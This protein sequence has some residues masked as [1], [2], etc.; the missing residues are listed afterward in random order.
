MGISLPEN[1]PPKT[2]HDHDHDISETLGKLSLNQNE[3]ADLLLESVEK[4]LAKISLVI[5]EEE[6][7]GEEKGDKEEEKEEE[8][9]GDKEEEEEEE[10]KKIS[11]D[12]VIEWKKQVNDDVK[13]DKKEIYDDVKNDK[14]KIVDVGLREEKTEVKEEE[15]DEVKEE[16]EK[17][18]EEEEEEEVK[19]LTVKKEDVYDNDDKEEEEKEEKKNK[20]KE[21]EED[22][23]MTHKI[24]KLSEKVNTDLVMDGVRRVVSK[25]DTTHTDTHTTTTT[26]PPGSPKTSTEKPK[27]RSR[28]LMG[29]ASVPQGSY[30][31]QNS[32]ESVDSPS[33]T[34]SMSPAYHCDN[35]GI[36]EHFNFQQSPAGFHLPISPALSNTDDGETWPQQQQQQ[37]QYYSNNQYIYSDHLQYNQQQQ[38]QQQQ[39]PRQLLYDH[40]RALQQQQQQYQYQQQQQQQQYQQQPQVPDVCAPLQFEDSRSPLMFPDASYSP[41]TQQQQQQQLI[42]FQSG[43]LLSH[44]PVQQVPLTAGEDSLDIA[45]VIDAIKNECLNP[46]TL[47]ISEADIHPIKQSLMQSIYEVQPY[48]EAPQQ[49]QQQQQNYHHQQQQQ[50]Q[51]QYSPD[52]HHLNQ[53]QHQQQQLQHCNNLIS[54]SSSSSPPPTQ[55][56]GINC[57]SNSPDRNWK[58]V[59][60]DAILSKHRLEFALHKNERMVELDSDGDTPTMIFACQQAKTKPEYAEALCAIVERQK[61]VNIH[62]NLPVEER[63]DGGVCRKCGISEQSAFYSSLSLK[64]KQGYSVL[65]SVIALR[66][67]SAVIKFLLKHLRQS[68]LPRIFNKNDHI[69]TWAAEAYPELQPYVIRYC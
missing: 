5:T 32:I 49:Q 6:E 39:Q 27:L 13:N 55:L 48:L 40:E 52:Y 23:D 2:D 4:S 66:H 43:Q 24:K 65:T 11:K 62:C 56:Q 51:Q 12:G 3:P 20:K 26:S 67:P 16:T 18:E 9:K 17:G 19:K 14:K 7:E 25:D 33:S 34:Y 64:N 31:L 15:E 1:D 68:D 58:M 60:D 44:E 29:F 46:N 22:E 50:Q 61:N 38:Q 41:T 35:V 21:E 28:G 53:Q 59:C 10:E 8:E 45:H 57:N 63:V 54:T 47:A 37:Q 42:G 36:N 69:F 30:E